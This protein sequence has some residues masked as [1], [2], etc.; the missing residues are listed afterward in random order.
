MC[1]HTDFIIKKGALWAQITGYQVQINLWKPGSL[2]NPSTIV[3]S[4]FCSPFSPPAGSRYATPYHT[5]I[6]GVGI[7][8]Y[9]CC[10][11]NRN[12]GRASGLNSDWMSPQ[13]AGATMETAEPPLKA[14]LVSSK[15]TSLISLRTYK[16]DSISISF[17]FSFTLVFISN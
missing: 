3:T 11:D 4:S 16:G 17:I 13:D 1:R 7:G 2:E 8:E 12:D 15:L 14:L 9:L 5:M 10:S 6:N